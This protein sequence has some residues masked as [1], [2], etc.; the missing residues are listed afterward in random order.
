LCFGRRTSLTHRRIRQRGSERPDVGGGRT[1]GLVSRF[2]E[3]KEET[4][5]GKTRIKDKDDV[6]T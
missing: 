6:L 3:R 4:F 2:G 5:E 1:S